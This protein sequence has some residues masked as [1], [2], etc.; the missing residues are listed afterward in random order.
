MG[1]RVPKA[2]EITSHAVQ[3]WAN[4][5]RSDESLILVDFANAYN[6]VDRQKVL[7]AVA[8][9]APSFLPYANFCYGSETPLRGRDFLLWSAEGTQQGDC[10]GPVFFSV[11][12]QQLLR[13]CCPP[14]AQAWNRWYLDDG[15][16]CGQTSAVE[17]MFNRLV[18][19][20]PDF[21]LQ[22]NVQKCKQ[23][24]PVPSQTAL[25]PG[26]PWDSGVK[27]LGVPVGSPG[28]IQ[29]YSRRVLS[30]LQGCLERL[31]LLGC[32][33]SGFH[34][35]RSCLSA[36]KVMFLLRTLPYDMALGLATEAQERLR[37]TLADMLDMPLADTQ[38]ALARLPVRKGG[39]GI[40]DPVTAAAPAHVASFLSSSAGALAHDLPSC[41]APQSFFTALA[42]LSQSSPAH[43]SALR[44]L[45]RVGHPLAA[46]VAQRELFDTWCDQHQWTGAVHE[47]SCGLLD[48]TLPLRLRRLREL[49]TG[50]H[51]GAWL[52]APSPGCHSHKWSS[53]EWRL[54]LLWRLGC[55]M[56]LP[57][58][59]VAC[60]AKM[61][62]GTTH[63]LVPRWGCTGATTQCATLSS[64]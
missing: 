10:C 27:V 62:T 1:V 56:E 42:S 26:V 4:A 46:D 35:L 49:A 37:A 13:E 31:K 2:A 16:L 32:T 15:T 17:A 5:A 23:W 22:V 8:L 36:C 20:S 40:L 44:T 14:S 58:A 28:F 51:A 61:C 60:G 52:L 25:A 55:P 29:D 7:G 39:L 9:E 50:A 18:H 45:V 41:E 33:F 24:G 3:A 11:T 34:I 59:C 38:W 54:L 64:T 63:C 43:A 30:K 6:S 19:K 48:S 53:V 57:V 47:C 12:L 21:G